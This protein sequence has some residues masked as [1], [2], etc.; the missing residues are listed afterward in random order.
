MHEVPLGRAVQTL[1][2]SLRVKCRN[3]E[4]LNIEAPLEVA[5]ILISAL[6]SVVRLLRGP[7]A[8]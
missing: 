5:P 6:E 1:I 7:E 8:R 3:G 2:A 4:V